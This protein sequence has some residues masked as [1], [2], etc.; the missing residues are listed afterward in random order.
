[1]LLPL[2]YLRAENF[3]HIQEYCANHPEADKKKLYEEAKEIE[4]LLRRVQST[5]AS[6]DQIEYIKQLLR[7][8]SEGAQLPYQREVLR[9]II[10]NQY[11]PEET[12][13][14]ASRKLYGLTAPHRLLFRDM[15]RRLPQ[16]ASA[17]RSACVAA[18]AAIGS[19]HP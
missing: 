3:Q 11:A 5:N 6:E 2:S 12:R 7:V 15:R 14:F 18:L 9:E 16:I 8:D 13:N 19:Q 4:R 10:N 1:M 17:A